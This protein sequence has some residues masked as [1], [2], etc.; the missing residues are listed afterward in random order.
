MGAD[1]RLS[2]DAVGAHTLIAAEHR[3]RYRFAARAATGKRVIDLCCGVGYG[4]GI[5]MDEA[6]A[7]LGVDR[8]AAA[9]DTAAASVGRDTGASF[10]AADALDHLRR[11][12]PGDV[13]LVVCFEG[14]EHVDDPG[15]VVDELARL[16]RGGVGIIASVPNSATFGEENEYHVTD[17]DLRSARE[18]FA[19]L[20]D[21]VIAFQ[22]HAEG[23]L[24]RG[25]SGGEVRA[26]VQLDG[27]QD[28]DWAN[29]FL[30]LSGV[31]ADDLLAPADALTHLALGPV[32]HRYMRGLERANAELRSANGR[33]ARERLGL[34]AGGA[35]AAVLRRE[36]EVDVLR[37]LLAAAEAERDAAQAAEAVAREQ[38]DQ[39]RA[40]TA[41]LRAERDDYRRA[42]VVV[43][44]SRLTRLAARAAGHRF[45]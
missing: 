25:R 28:L 34:G 33:L 36:D 14:L 44:H 40:T 27:E 7:V 37:S 15:R 11:T 31:D 21:P 17:F 24:I 3:H 12:E 9:V 42:H 5:L 22:T 19:R 8:D 4:S 10:A 43:R 26:T 32:N 20:P 23:T 13:D 45:D 35:A 38:V 30:V 1:E 39:E 41:E 18:L 29:Q 2:L 6:S 16:A